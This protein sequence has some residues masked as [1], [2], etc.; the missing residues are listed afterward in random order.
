MTNSIIGKD[1]SRQSVKN[2][3]F[4][5]AQAAFVLIVLAFLLGGFTA[6][7]VKVA[8]WGSKNRIVLKWPLSVSR[9][10][11]VSIE[12]REAEVQVLVSNVADKVAGEKLTPVEQKIMDIWGYKNGVVA[13]AIFDCG[14]SHLDQYAV[15]KTGDLGIAQINWPTWKK[16]VVEKFGYN[17]SDMFDVDKN[18]KVANWIYDR[19]GVKDSGDESWKAWSGF[20]NGAYTACFE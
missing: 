5:I 16:A 4:G 13:L 7:V 10:K 8:D 15:S 2:N 11:I 14:E 18:L 17:A 6:V 3:K 9:N 1:I 20:N 12:V 19:D